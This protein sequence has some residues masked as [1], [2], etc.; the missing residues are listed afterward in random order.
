MFSAL[1]ILSLFVGTEVKQLIKKE[2]QCQ[3]ILYTTENSAIAG[4]RYHMLGNQ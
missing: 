4:E 2:P 3:F 1:T